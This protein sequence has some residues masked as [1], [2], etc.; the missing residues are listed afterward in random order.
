MGKNPSMN[1]KRDDIMGLYNVGQ[2]HEIKN[3][4]PDIALLERE[5]KRW[6]YQSIKLC[7]MVEWKI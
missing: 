2:N 6:V 1:I 7:D 5:S 4:K 3:S